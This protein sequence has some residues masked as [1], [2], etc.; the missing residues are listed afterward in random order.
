MV[1]CHK[2]KKKAV[3]VENKIYYC[4]LCML[5]KLGIKPVLQLG[6]RGN[7]T[8]EIKLKESTKK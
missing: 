5:L 2:C 1:N 8:E 4:G 3:V 6:A 7:I